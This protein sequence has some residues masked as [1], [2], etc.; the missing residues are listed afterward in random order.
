MPNGTG[1]PGGCTRDLVHRFYKEQY[2]I[3]G[4]RQ[5][6]YA[7]GSDAVGL[8]MGTYD[9]TELP[10]YKYLHGRGHPHYAIADHFFQAA[11]GGSFL[12]HQWLIAAATPTWPGAVADG[13][14]TTCTRSSTRNGMPTQATRCYTADRRRS[15]DHAR[16][17]VACPAAA[18]GPLCGDYAV[19]TIQ[20][21]TSRTRRDGRRAGCRRRRRRPSA[22]G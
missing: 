2:Q 3:N 21:P 17:T 6:R 9:T 19:N 1:L 20:P 15:S 16:L 13:R 5:D 22:T 7:T 18:G 14:P 11:F 4:G 10:I 12:N 8:T